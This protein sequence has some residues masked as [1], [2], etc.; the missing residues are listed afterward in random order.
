MKNKIIK[1]SPLVVACAL[2]STGAMA[3]DKVSAYGQARVS[4]DSSSLTATDGDV[5]GRKEGT[6]FK[7]NSSR[8]GLKGSLDTN[9]DDTKMI[10]KA[11]FQ[12]DFADDNDTGSLK[13]RDAFAGLKSKQY[14]KIQMGR[15]TVGYK[16]SYTKIDPW[17]DHTLQMREK[18]Q[19]GASDLYS[20]YFNNAVSYTSPNF[21]GVSVNA[22]YSFFND[23]ATIQL[24]NAGKLKDF[25]GGSASGFG[26]KYKA[27]GLRLTADSLTLDAKADPAD[28][29]TLKTKNGTALA[30]TA[31]YKFDS[32][33]TLAGLYE[34]VT[35]I[36]LGENMFVIVTQKVGQHG[37]VTAGYGTNIAGKNNLYSA[38]DDSTNMNVGAKYFLNKKSALILGYN[39][40][41]RGDEDSSTFTMGVDIKFGY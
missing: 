9:L 18:G 40:Y 11:E 24:H 4:L 23:E 14:G 38:K 32:G 10:Y 29:P 36:N 28:D 19:Q 20:N 27:G 31:Q 30:A 16:S 15:L 41:E 2:A 1:L 7:S 39:K 8:I 22:F 13:F 12:Y 3:E 25:K 37:V 35:D 6:T 33:T 5:L 26:V 34:D 21:N 17:T